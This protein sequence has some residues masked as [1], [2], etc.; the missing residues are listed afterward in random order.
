MR[1]ITNQ[2]LCVIAG[3]GDEVVPSVIIMGQ[4]PIGSSS[5]GGLTGA[6][7]LNFAP[8]GSLGATPQQ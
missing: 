6:A 8:K 2:E 1:L 4:R 3:G 5:S 7:G